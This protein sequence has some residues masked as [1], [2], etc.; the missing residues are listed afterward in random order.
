LSE[1]ARLDALQFQIP[2]CVIIP[3][4]IFRTGPYAVISACAV[5]VGS[6]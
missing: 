3:N 2:V 5:Y 1:L 4:Q 6:S